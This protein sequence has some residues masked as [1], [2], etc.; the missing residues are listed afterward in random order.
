M[1]F[2]SSKKRSYSRH[3]QSTT[4]HEGTDCVWPGLV[5]MKIS[6]SITTTAELAV[7]RR[8]VGGASHLDGYFYILVPQICDVHLG[9]GVRV[10][11]GRG[12]TSVSSLS[13]PCVAE[14]NLLSSQ[15]L[16]SCSIS[17]IV[18]G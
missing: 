13:Y 5:L 4:S 8:K 2:K 18:V 15:M 6:Q 1:S 9:A 17:D 12:R 3:Y 7:V 16:G 14:V 11:T 10:V